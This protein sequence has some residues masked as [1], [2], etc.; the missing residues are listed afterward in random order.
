VIDRK[1][2]PGQFILT[3]FTNILLLPQVSDS[4]AGHME[5]LALWPLSQGEIHGRKE[6]FID[7]LFTPKIIRH[8]H[9]ADTNTL[10]GY[11]E[12]ILR[13]NSGEKIYSGHRALHR[14]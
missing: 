14:K 12:V 7:A 8:H 11:P 10:G 9:L 4:L 6:D 5:I 3:G 1:R 2:I 13:R